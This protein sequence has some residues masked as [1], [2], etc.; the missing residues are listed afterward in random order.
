MTESSIKRASLAEL[1]RM[2]ESGLIREDAAAPDGGDLGPDFWANAVIEERGCDP[3]RS[4]EARSGRVRFLPGRGR[5]QGPHH[6][7]AERAEG[8]CQGA[9]PVRRGLTLTPPPWPW[10]GPAVRPE[11]RQPPRRCL[12]RPVAVAGRRRRSRPPRP[13]HR[14]CRAASRLCQHAAVEVGL[15]TAQRLAG[16]DVQ[17]T[18]MS[19]PFFGSRILCGGA[20]RM[21]RSPR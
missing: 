2:N 9:G 18:A 5:R 17:F 4:P 21:S 6:A 14:H 13:P 8:L 16:E 1:R 7:D 11:N 12:Q 3:V 20:V 15:Q 10:P 19:G